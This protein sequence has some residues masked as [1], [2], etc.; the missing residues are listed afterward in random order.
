M[1]VTAQNIADFLNT[2][3]S[4]ENIVVTQPATADAPADQSVIFLKS[5]NRELLQNLSGFE[6]LLLVPEDESVEIEHPH[7]RCGNPRLAFAKVVRT[8]FEEKQE[9]GIDPTAVLADDVVCGKNISI[10]K[11]SVVET[12]V[13]IGDDT[14]IRDQ[15]IIRKGTRIGKHCL[16]KSGVIIGEEG[17]G[18]DFEE[19]GT[20]VRMPHTGGVIIGDRV[21]LGSDTVI[22]RGTIGDTVLKDDVKVNDLVHIAHN[23]VVGEKTIIAGGKLCGSVELGKGV[24]MAPASIVKNKVKVGADTTI[25]LGAVVVKDL[26][27]GVVAFGNPAKVA[28]SKS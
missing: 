19:D 5:V 9:A 8:Y 25:G 22:C 18:F 13:V 12:G 28:R 21:E 3:L 2:P 6:L 15:V 20:P 1:T 14:V 7:I 23:C 4:G 26:K 16:I 11:H 17:F 10:G 27:A 24:W